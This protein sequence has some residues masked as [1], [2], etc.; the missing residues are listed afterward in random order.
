VLGSSVRG[1][2]NLAL[3]RALAPESGTFRTQRRFPDSVVAQ[4]RVI[5]SVEMSS[6]RV[7]HAVLETNTTQAQL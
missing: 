7:A 5:Y 3:A 1:G 2:A 6:I 4:R